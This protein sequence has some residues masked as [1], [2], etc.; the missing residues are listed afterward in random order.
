MALTPR[1]RKILASIENEISEKDP[2]LAAMLNNMPVGSGARKW[3]P[4][5]AR[6]VLLLIAALTMLAALSPTISQLGVAAIAACTVALIVPW[7]MSAARAALARGSAP[8]ER[9]DTGLTEAPAGPPVMSLPSV[10]EGTRRRSGISVFTTIVWATDGSPSA[11]K[12][13]P[14]A[15]GLA[16][17]TGARLVVAHVEEVVIG[18][19][20]A[21]VSTANEAL[22]TALQQN[23]RTLEREGIRVEFRSRQ[24]PAGNAAA[25]IVDLAKDMGADLIVAGTRGRG[26][27][28]GLI[29]G[30]VALRLLQTPLPGPDRARAARLTRR[31][32]RPGT[33]SEGLF[34]LATVG[35]V[36]F[37][38]TA[39]YGAIKRQSARRNL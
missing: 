12:A 36:L 23:M 19:A 18:R 15:K 35:A 9:E 14:L 26:P 16:R 5:S 37:I 28:A 32:D 30:S 20:G 11:D 22:K 34:W 25:A 2:R 10:R 21:P 4:V 31:S 17:T 3:L 29:L 24:A 27:L 8:E 7:L 6:H 39:A 33:I 38:A 1:E 13:L